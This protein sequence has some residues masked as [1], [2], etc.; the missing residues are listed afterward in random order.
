MEITG[1]TLYDL[2]RYAKKNDILEKEQLSEVL[3]IFCELRDNGLNLNNV[4]LSIS[5]TKIGKF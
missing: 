4:T 5:V 1:T 3:K 2:T